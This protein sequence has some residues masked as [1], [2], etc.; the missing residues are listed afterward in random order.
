M[1][2]LVEA[3][4]PPRM[5]ETFE[6]HHEVDFAYSVPSLGRFRVNAFYQRSTVAVVLRRVRTSAASAGN[7]AC[8][9]RSTTWQ[10]SSEA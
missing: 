2:L 7:W 8:R 9:R 5:S 3:M 4:L 6:R 1:E 10:L